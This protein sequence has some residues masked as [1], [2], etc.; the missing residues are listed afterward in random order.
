MKYFFV[1]IALVWALMG[2]RED[3][4]KGYKDHGDFFSNPKFGGDYGKTLPLNSVDST[5]ERI[6]LDVPEIWQSWACENAYYNMS[7]A[8]P[9]SFFFAYLDKIERTFPNDSLRAFAQLIRGELFSTAGRF[10]TALVCYNDS[11]DTYVKCNRLLYAS[12]AQFMMGNLAAVRGDYPEGIRL[13]TISYNIAASMKGAD[14][15]RLVNTMFAL[16]RMYRNIEDYEM[17]RYWYKKLWQLTF[18]FDSM[19]DHQIQTTGLLAE[20]YLFMD[21][22]DSAKILIDTTFKLMDSYQMRTNEG[23]Y[24]VI[25]AEIQVALGKCKE[26]MT[27]FESAPLGD[28]GTFA[29]LRVRSK[30]NRGL[31]LAY[32]CLGKSDSA[33]QCFQRALNTTDTLRQADILLQLAKVYEKKGNISLALDAQRRS[34][35]LRSRIIT[36]RKDRALENTRVQN[37]AEQRIK[38]VE[39]E[40]EKMRLWSIIS[41][42]VLVFSLIVVLFVAYRQKQRRR[43]VEREKELAEARAVIQ[44]Q[45]LAKTEAALLEKAV[46]LNISERLLALKNALIAELQLKINENTDVFQASQEEITARRTESNASR[47]GNTQ[48]DEDVEPNTDAVKEE[49]YR[50]KIL[51]NDDWQRFKER[52]DEVFPSFNSQLKREHKDLTGAEIRLFILLRIGFS[53]AEIASCLGISPD[54]VYKSRYR[55]RKK[56]GLPDD[57]DLTAFIQDF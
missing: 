2:C 49:F 55:L 48:S 8:L 52:F 26:A 6:V 11:Y 19:R 57:V 5:V 54:S 56:L 39:H 47:D 18:S 43:L 33:V 37:E 9:D 15:G 7:D 34:Q 51:T 38:D 53:S 32:V 23:T 12:D 3:K 36:S 4:T 13:A 10:D 21:N 45:R 50:M 35:D 44:A 22:L 14:E 30:L 29:Q 40:Q 17:A 16:A 46:A 1:S 42:L 31:G 41:V 24:K 25:R 27:D 28:A 20:N